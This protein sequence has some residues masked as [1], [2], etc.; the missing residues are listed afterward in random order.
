MGKFLEKYGYDLVINELL[1]D[2]FC[3][4]LED[5]YYES[6][7]PELKHFLV[8]GFAGLANMSDEQL[9]EL[10][11]RWAHDQEFFDQQEIR[12]AQWLKDNKRVQS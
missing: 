7:W 8:N 1:P 2:A 12:M 6:G 3:R 9:E 11:Q 5:H 4:R 10:C